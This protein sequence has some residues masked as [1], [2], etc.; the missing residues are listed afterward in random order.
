VRPIKLDERHIPHE[1]VRQLRPHPQMGTRPD[2]DLGVV[3]LGGL[4]ARRPPRRLVG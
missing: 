2:G 4:E 3:G 1:R